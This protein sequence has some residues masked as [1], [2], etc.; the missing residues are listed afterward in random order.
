MV[1]FLKL[2]G[3]EEMLADDIA[4]VFVV[5]ERDA[6]KHAIQKHKLH[7]FVDEGDDLAF[8]IAHNARI[9]A[10]KQDGRV[11]GS[12]H[13]SLSSVVSVCLHYNVTSGATSSVYSSIMCSWAT[14]TKAWATDMTPW[15]T[16]PLAIR[17]SGAAK[18]A[19]TIPA[20]LRISPPGLI[21]NN[22]STTNPFHLDYI[23]SDRSKLFDKTIDR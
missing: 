17:S 12:V 14:S 3:R 4:S 11:K 13:F 19:S 20:L 10:R 18:W 16:L 9:E 23:T 21:K 6:S 22:L 1:F 15:K 8:G 5:I 7:V 2:L